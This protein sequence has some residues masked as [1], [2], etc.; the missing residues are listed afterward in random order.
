MFNISWYQKNYSNFLSEHTP[1]LPKDINGI[2][3]STGRF[4]SGVA[5]MPH[6]S[7]PIREPS[8]K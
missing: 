4:K 6:M 8:Y 2:R 7:F 5:D 3:S 1:E